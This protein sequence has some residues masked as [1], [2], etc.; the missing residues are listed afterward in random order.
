MKKHEG[1]LEKE[2]ETINWNLAK[3]LEELIDEIDVLKQNREEREKLEKMTERFQRVAEKQHQQI[4]RMERKLQQMVNVAMGFVLLIL[5]FL[6]F[7][8]INRGWNMWT[9]AKQEHRH[10]V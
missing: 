9:T 8:S 10:T 4:A 5:F 6:L 1:K 3:D 2:L 7:A